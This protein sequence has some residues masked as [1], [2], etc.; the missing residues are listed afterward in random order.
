MNL[1][2]LDKAVNLRSQLKR[3]RDQLQGV[4]IGGITLSGY[5]VSLHVS[6]E[7]SSS[8]K[9]LVIADLEKQEKSLLAE[10]QK[11]GVTEGED[12]AAPKMSDPLK[13]A[14]ISSLIMGPLM[15]RRGDLNGSRG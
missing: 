3:V 15:A 6:K 1:S 10:L 7:T 12:E 2:N 11:L 9:T 8:V 5:A 13:E 14:I 4:R